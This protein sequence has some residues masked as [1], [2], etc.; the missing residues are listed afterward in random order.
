MWYGSR[1]QLDV[2]RDVASNV[3]LR[4]LGVETETEASMKFGWNLVVADEVVMHRTAIQGT[5]RCPR[6]SCQRPLGS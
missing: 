1:P 4:F 3:L 5:M 6:R 2:H